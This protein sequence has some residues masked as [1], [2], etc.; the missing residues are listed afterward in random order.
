MIIGCEAS[1]N[2]LYTD[3][4]NSARGDCW[5]VG[6]QSRDLIIK[7]RDGSCLHFKYPR[8][9]NHLDGRIV[10]YLHFHQPRALIIKPELSTLSWPLD[11]IAILNLLAP[12]CLINVTNAAWMVLRSFVKIDMNIQTFALNMNVN[13]SSLQGPANLHFLQFPKWPCMYSDSSSSTDFQES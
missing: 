2:I 11:L 4:H 9:N 1:K 12:F 7:I 5:R 3:L 13:K 8:N 6:S 10:I